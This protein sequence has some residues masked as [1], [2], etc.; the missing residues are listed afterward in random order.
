MAIVLA[1]TEEQIAH[2]DECLLAE[3]GTSWRKVA[4]V[5]GRLFTKPPEGFAP[6]PAGYLAQRVQ[7][8]VAAG[9]LDSQ[10]NLDYMRFS[11]VRLPDS[12]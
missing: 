2:I 12:E 6:L 8:L 7:V 9:R 4:R 10:G 5:A 1:L 3:C 11:E